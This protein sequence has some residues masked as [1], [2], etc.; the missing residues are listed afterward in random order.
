[1]W[2]AVLQILAVVAT[3]GII[4]AGSVQLNSTGDFHLQWC[5]EDNASTIDCWVK[6]HNRNV[7]I[8]FYALAVIVMGCVVLCSELRTHHLTR[9]PGAILLPG[10][11]A[12]GAA[13][14]TGLVFGGLAIIVG[15]LQL[16]TFLCTG[17]RQ[18]PFSFEGKEVPRV[19]VLITKYSMAIGMLGVCCVGGA[20]IYSVA[21]GDASTSPDIVGLEWCTHPDSVRCWLRASYSAFAVGAYGACLVFCGLAGFCAVLDLVHGFQDMYAHHILGPFAILV[22]ILCLG[23]AGNSGILAGSATI[24]SGI[25]TYFLSVLFPSGYHRIQ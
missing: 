6:N 19:F 22:G 25:F 18:G 16:V 3:L 20:C 14:N 11:L 17:S 9:P 2:T 23:A 5:S 10:I 24:A 8:T 15:L 13:N 7:A 4:L 12:V 1:M 21:N